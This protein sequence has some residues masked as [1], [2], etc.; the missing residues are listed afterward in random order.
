MKLTSELNLGFSLKEEQKT[1]IVAL[2]KGQ[3][4]FGVLPT[5][6]GKSMTYIL[7]PILMDKVIYIERCFYV[8]IDLH[9][10]MSLSQ[11]QI[12]WHLRA[13]RKSIVD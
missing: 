11:G 3:D 10:C 5:G 7:L 6:F 1:I 12:F 4:A 13:I 8:H 2:S 9:V